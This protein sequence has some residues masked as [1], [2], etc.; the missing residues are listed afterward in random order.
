MATEPQIK[1]EPRVDILAAA[2]MLEVRD[3][4]RMVRPGLYLG[5]AYLGR[6]FLL[7]FTLE[8]LDDK[9]RKAPIDDCEI[10]PQRMALLSAPG[11]QPKECMSMNEYRQL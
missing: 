9:C 1:Y 6:I 2:S 3:E 5:R 10:G 4:I 11:Q 7:N 8:C